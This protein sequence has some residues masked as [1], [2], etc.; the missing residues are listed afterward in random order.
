MDLGRK[1]CTWLHLAVL[2]WTWLDYWIWV[3]LSGLVGTCINLGGLG[4]TWLD[5]GELGWT[6]VYLGRHG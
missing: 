4:W 1:G 2:G 3:N 6:W 5:L